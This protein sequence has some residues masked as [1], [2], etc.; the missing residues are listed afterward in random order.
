MPLEGVAALVILLRIP[1]EMKNAFLFGFSIQ[2]LIVAGI[3]VAMIAGF[4]LF[5]FAAFQQPAWWQR[6]SI[7][8]SDFFS[9]RARLFGVVVLLSTIFLGITSFLFLANSAAV[10][11]LVVLASL[12]ERLGL[13]VIWIGLLI[14]QAGVLILINPAVRTNS[15]PFLTPPRFS[16]FLTI[17][18]IFYVVTLRIYIA[19]TYSNQMESLESYIFLPAVVSMIWGM[20]YH[21]FRDRTWFRSAAFL[22]Q[23]VLIGVAIYTI[24]RHTGQWL[25]L[26]DT[27]TLA[28]WHLLA[29]SF[30]KGRLYIENPPT[31]YDLTYFHGHW[32]LPPGPLPALLLVPLVAVLGAAQV[33]M[34]LF[35]IVFGGINAALIFLVL[36]QASTKK[37]ISTS[38]STNLWLTFIFSFGTALWWLSILGQEWYVSQILTVTFCTLSVWFA[39]KKS[40]PLLVG[41]F[42]GLAVLARPS[43]IF[44]WPL[45]AGI[46]FH[47]DKLDHKLLNWRKLAAWSIQ[48]AIPVCLASG[49]L[50]FYNYLRF[51]N[52][53]DF[54]Y[55]TING[56]APIIAAARQYG[57]FNLH[58]VPT[59]LEIMLFRLP[60]VQI[61]NGCLAYN[62][63]REGI[64]IFAMTP[65]VF[66]IFR[67]IKFNW[68]TAG[69]W[70]SSILSGGL[71][72]MY[73]TTGSSQLGYRYI[74]DFILPIFMLMAL[75]VGQKTSIIFKI[76]ALF[77]I[78]INLA[79]IL[80]WFG[81]WPC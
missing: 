61:V 31:V 23:L 70:I 59:N 64:S 20:Q 15:E 36:D 40:N 56:A 68:W 24:Y 35:S 48:T 14:L 29:E 51:D 81:K 16:I 1:S 37:L 42:L 3:T 67:R 11:T 45:L 79:G 7:R 34:F 78:L 50:L 17:A 75:G 52:F 57:I 28:Y 18:T 25:N 6:S 65:A 27:P 2:R 54:G 60:S 69:A 33:N 49:A 66:Y 22:N 80:W 4:G 21:F 13:L 58:F 76:L 47:L 39:L 8:F 10:K 73:H 44:L 9:S 30:L 72:L 55:V 71:L 46:T 53:F 62:P 19:A 41:L 77:S 63:G 38:R 26:T 43:V 74:T 32:Y 5:G 12:N